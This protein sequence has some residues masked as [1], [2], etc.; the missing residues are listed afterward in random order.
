M[1]QHFWD[2]AVSK[3]GYLINR[4]PTPILNHCSP[5]YCLFKIQPNYSLLR[6]FDCA[7]YLNLHPY[8][9]H[10][11][12]QCFDRC[13]PCRSIGS[14]TV[15]YHSITYTRSPWLLFP[16]LSASCRLAIISWPTESSCYGCS[17]HS[18]LSSSAILTQLTH[19]SCGSTS[20][21]RSTWYLSTSTHVISCRV[22]WY[23]FPSLPLRTFPFRGLVLKLTGRYGAH[24]QALWPLVRTPFVR[25]KWLH[26]PT[27]SAV[28]GQWIG[29][30]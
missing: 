16:H 9:T 4:F 6:I 2:E 7:Y 14:S 25:F 21:S 26:P 8:A 27:R 10:K 23:Y 13:L 17:R 30:Q 28:N 12:T 18:S 19:L 20:L 24:D 3:I 11:L 15:V 5:Y 1:P 22:I 29:Q